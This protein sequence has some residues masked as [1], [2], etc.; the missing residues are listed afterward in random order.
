MMQAPG[1]LSKN[2][3][4]LLMRTFLNGLLAM[5]LVGLGVLA[6]EKAPPEKLVFMTKNGNV[7]FNHAD[8]IKRANGDC[9]TCHDKLFPKS[10]T[11]PLNYKPTLHK[12]AEMDKTSCGACHRAGGAAFESKGNCAKCHMKG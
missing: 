7:T 11:A 2:A 10:A 4:F 9:S 6:Q 5:A 3:T 1:Q 8:H 12:A